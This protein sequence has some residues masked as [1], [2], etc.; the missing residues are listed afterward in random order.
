MKR[1][2]DFE[3]RRKH[4]ANLS[5]EELYDRFW[6]LT[7]EIVRPLIDLAYNN[8][9]S[10]IERSVL[11]R[12]GF[13]SLEAQAIVGEGVKAGL[14]GKGIGNIV[15]KYAELKQMPY[16]EAGRELGEGKGW[17]EVVNLFNGGVSSC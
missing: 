10:S 2:D 8:T 7:E 9:S 1:E 6:S 14:L 4:L 15:L 13:S 11:L 3:V 16:L 5:D 17:N 12:M